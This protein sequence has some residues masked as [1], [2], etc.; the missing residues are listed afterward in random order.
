[1]RSTSRGVR[2]V[3]CTLLFSDVSLTC[4]CIEGR[5]AA[6]KAAPKSRKRIDDSDDESGPR[7]IKRARSGASAGGRLPAVPEVILS[8]SATARN[9]RLRR[10]LHHME[11]AF[12]LAKGMFVEEPPTARGALSTG[13]V[14]GPSTRSRVGAGAGASAKGKGK[15]RAVAVED[16]EVDEESSGDGEGSGGSA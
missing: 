14:A 9:E 4:L 16:M 6:P 15:A 13:P 5:N 2:T 10:F 3:S 7:P 1:V 12:L 8:E 11:A